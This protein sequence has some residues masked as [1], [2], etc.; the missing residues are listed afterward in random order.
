MAT[1]TKVIVANE[2][3]QISVGLKGVFVNRGA[4]N[5]QMLVAETQPAASA[6]G[7][8]MQVAKRYVYELAGSELVWAKSNGGQTNVGVT[9]A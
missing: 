5:G 6:E 2:Y 3:R 1:E 4:V 7:D 8:P 9:P